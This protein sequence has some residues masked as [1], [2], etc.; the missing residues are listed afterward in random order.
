MNRTGL[1]MVLLVL[2]GLTSCAETEGVRAYQQQRVIEGAE[3]EAVLAEAA[4][5]LR[6]E[7][8]RVRLELPGRRLVTTPAEFT[9]NRESG[10][11]RDIY[12]GRTT[13]RRTATF[14]VGRRGGATVAWLR[15]DVERLD[16]VRQ[17]VMH[18]RG[19]RISDTPGS[20]TPIDRDAATTEEQNTVWTHVRRD[21]S[22]ERTLL[23]EL[24]ER[25]VPVSAESGIPETGAEPSDETSGTQTRD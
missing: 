19:H 14:D 12:R 13:M 18:P 23:E 4:T 17:R 16:T 3:P 9:T 1:F 7:F 25:F 11:A 24:R 8:G 15:I 5:I 20:E 2:A 21:R 6:R 22:L 10:T